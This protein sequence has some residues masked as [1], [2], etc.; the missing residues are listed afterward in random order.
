M[1]ASLNHETVFTVLREAVRRRTPRSLAT[2]LGLSVVTGASILLIA[3]H[4]WSIAFLAG[5]SGTYSAWG[6]L[7]RYAETRMLHAR[8]FRALLVM[9]AGLGTA[10]AIA[11]LWGIGLAFYTGEA[12]GAKTTCGPRSTSAYC[13]ASL[14]PPQAAGPLIL[15]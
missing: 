9:V 13:Q 8:P 7:A 2:Q 5:W 14:H 10:F 3:P 15:K 6:L 4:W 11:G 1:V 12:P